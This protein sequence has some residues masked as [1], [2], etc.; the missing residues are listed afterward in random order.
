M[1]I[2]FNENRLITADCDSGKRQTRPL[3]RE[4]APHQQACS[5]LTEIKICLKP[6]IGA[7]YQ[8]RLVD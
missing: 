1:R 7:L 5:C 2:V 4:S 8:D 6:H 3:V